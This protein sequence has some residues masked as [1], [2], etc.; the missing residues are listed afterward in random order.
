MAAVD[1]YDNAFGQKFS[2][3][4][5]SRVSRIELLS[6]SLQ[7]QHAFGAICDGQLVGLAGYQG[8]A[9]SLT[10]GVNYRM[11]IFTARSRSGNL[12]GDDFRAVRA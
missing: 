6:N 8:A 5:R 10:G 4:I 11:L 7:L 1:L 12:G 2:V 9:G 3:A